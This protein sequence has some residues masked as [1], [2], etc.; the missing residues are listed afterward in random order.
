MR[1]EG[2]LE[3]FNRT[4]RRLVGDKMTSQLT[5][6]ATRRRRVLREVYK[7]RARLLFT[8]LRIAPSQH[9]AGT[10]FV[11]V[12]DED[13]VTRLSA[14]RPTL[15]SLAC[16]GPTRECLGEFGH[17]RLRITAL[18]AECV[19]LKNL[20]RE[21]LIEAAITP[22]ANQRIGSDRLGLIQVEEHPGVLRHCD[23][24]V[25]KAP[26]EI[27]ANDFALIESDPRDGGCLGRSDGEMIGPEINQSFGEI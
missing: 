21:V 11:P 23:Q 12:S 22:Q 15:G 1:E 17:V 20:S 27:G 7:N 24:Q 2:G 8:A 6:N 19:E 14:R 3:L 4:H 18:N 13:K 26:R 10:G 9:V 5:R 16:N 25:A